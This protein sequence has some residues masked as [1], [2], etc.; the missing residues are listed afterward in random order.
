MI[1]TVVVIIDVI[2]III[3]VQQTAALVVGLQT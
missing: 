3:Q 1:I 2:S